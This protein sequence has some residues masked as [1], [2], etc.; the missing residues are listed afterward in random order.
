M[1][2]ACTIM[3]AHRI[4][5]IAH[6]LPR[7]LRHML[8]LVPISGTTA[9]C[10]HQSKSYSVGPVCT[11]VERTNLVKVANCAKQASFPNRVQK[12]TVS[13]KNAAGISTRIERVLT[14]AANVPR[15]SILKV[16]KERNNALKK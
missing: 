16:K 14:L 11:S 9:R 6:A 7:R 13:V 2:V 12:E 1:R 3:D 5:I 4:A 8:W 10:S 15:V